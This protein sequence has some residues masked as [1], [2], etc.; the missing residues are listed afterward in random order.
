MG[1]G[2]KSNKGDLLHGKEYDGETDVVRDHR[3]ELPPWD[4]RIIESLPEGVKSKQ[5]FKIAMTYPDTESR[6]VASK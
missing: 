5:K 6:E 1:A 4:L 2:K 3:E